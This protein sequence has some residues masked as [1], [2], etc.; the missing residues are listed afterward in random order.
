M[1]TYLLAIAEPFGEVQRE[2][3]AGLEFAQQT[4]YGYI[5]DIITT[6]L[7]LIRTLGSHSGIRLLQ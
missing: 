6:Q 2:A 5:A 1:V 7:R 3:E 4:R